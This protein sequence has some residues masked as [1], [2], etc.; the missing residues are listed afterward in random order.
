MSK[1]INLLKI[2]LFIFFLFS[3]NSLNTSL[4]ETLRVAYAARP[5]GLG[6]PF[7]S[8]VSGGLHPSTGIFDALTEIDGNGLLLPSLALSWERKSPINWVFKLRDNV[9][10]SNGEKFDSSSVISA[11]N[12]LKTDEAKR[13]FISGE[14]NIIKRVEAIDDLTL[15]FQTVSPDAIF[16]KRLSMLLIVPEVAWKE[17]GA[18]GFALEPVGTGPFML[19]D[20]GMKSGVVTIVR[21]YN[22]WRNAQNI[23]IINLIIVPEQIGRAQALLSNQADIAYSVGYDDLDML[24]KEGFLTLVREAPV[25][26]GLALPNIDKSHPLADKRVRQALN[27]G[28]N[29]QAI[30]DIILR[31]T[32]K[33]NG[34]GAIPGVFGYD[35]DI[36]PYPYDPDKALELLNEAG[37]NNG[38]KLRAD[39]IVGSGVPEA[40][41]I[42]QQIGQDLRSIGVEIEFH[43][44]ISTEWIQKWFSGNW[45]KADIISTIWNTSSYMDAIRAVENASCLKIGA[46]FCVPDMVDRIEATRGN[47]NVKTR[48]VQLQKLLADLHDLAPTLY[49]FPQT[50]NFAYTKKLKQLEFGRAQIK[51][52]RLI[53]EN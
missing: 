24:Q 42:Y 36:E 26:G 6:N 50:Y 11:I 1:K 40:A 44:A 32:T 15:E 5:P 37:Y 2:P 13:F 39:V 45:Q 21:N 20:W 22:S 3:I 31:G 7:A 49:L 43:S 25:V 14:T 19:K 18:S 4:A 28:T 47:F 41:L 9:Y 23:N 53:M 10:F 33:P 46:Y 16:P 48:K 34:Q 17:K 52:D 35:P 29:R 8:M 51:L 27:Y 38:L 30:A 12:Y